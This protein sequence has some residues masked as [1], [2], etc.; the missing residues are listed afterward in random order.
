MI[1]FAVVR[2]P[3]GGA[4]HR[5]SVGMSLSSPDDLQYKRRQSELMRNV[6]ERDSSGVFGVCSSLSEVSLAFGSR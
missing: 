3:A 2:G 1:F 5:W 6:D 4:A